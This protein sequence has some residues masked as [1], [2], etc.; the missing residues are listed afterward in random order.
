MLY[1]H[2][3][4]LCVLGI[5]V[6]WFANSIILLIRHRYRYDKRYKWLVDK[7]LLVIVFTRDRSDMCGLRMI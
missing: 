3:P 2:V 1:V 7:I 6:V 5:Y 4:T